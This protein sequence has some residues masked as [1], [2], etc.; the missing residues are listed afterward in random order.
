MLASTL[1]A[2][3]CEDISLVDLL[4]GCAGRWPLHVDKFIGKV[5][6]VLHA[7]IRGSVRESLTDQARSQAAS[8]VKIGVAIE[9]GFASLPSGLNNRL[10]Q[11]FSSPQAG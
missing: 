11:A 7:Q 3:M 9:V 1:L 2:P 4:N 5:S 6:L 8:G 10:L